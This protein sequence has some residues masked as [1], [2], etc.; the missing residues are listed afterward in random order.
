MSRPSSIFGVVFAVAT[1]ASPALASGDSPV[2]AANRYEE[3]HVFLKRILESKDSD[4]AILAALERFVQVGDPEKDMERR[5]GR[6]KTPL[7]N[8]SLVGGICWSFYRF[9]C[10]LGVIC[11]WGKVDTIY[12]LDRKLVK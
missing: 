9:E 7:P 3:P 12:Y 10:G 6:M 8:F 4:K 2:D 5:L 1:F 11:N